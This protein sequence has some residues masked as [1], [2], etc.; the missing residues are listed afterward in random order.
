MSPWD[1]WL[2]PRLWAATSSAVPV[3]SL[4]YFGRPTKLGF[5][6]A[7]YHD[8]MSDP[9]GHAGKYGPSEAPGDDAPPAS[10]APW[11]TG[12]ISR[13]IAAAVLALLVL[14]GVGAAAVGIVADAEAVI[15]LAVSGSA[16][17]A[18][19]FVAW[20]FGVRKHGLAWASLGFR[21]VPGGRSALLCFLAFIVC[22]AVAGF[23]GW[24]IEILG[25]DQGLPD[26]PF[27]EDGNR[28]IAAAGAGL[29][30][31]VAPMAEETFF[32]GFVFGGLRGRIGWWGAAGVSSGLFSLAHLLPLLYPPIFV[33][34]LVLAWVYAKTHSL[35]YPVLVHLGYNGVVVGISLSE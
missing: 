22:L 9:G 31:L 1:G 12:D 34:G 16:A 5:R 17:A 32:R 3:W 8:A 20:W 23:Y 18:L 26:R 28:A 10:Q 21:W 24:L 19:V 7:C 4:G 6:D 27:F 14:I 11:T 29:A 2:T 30:V 35:W 25:W 33:I 15:G 13:A